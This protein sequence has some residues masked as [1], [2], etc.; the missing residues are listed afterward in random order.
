MSTAA[1]EVPNVRRFV[2]FRIFFNARYYYPVFTILFLDF[3]L[4]LEQFTVLNVIWAL[5]IVFAEVPSGA[6]ADVVGRRNLLLSG[7]ILMLIEMAVLLV[8]PLNGGTLTLAL[9]AINRISSG[10]AEAM[11]SG[12]DEALAYDSLKKEGDPSAWTHVLEHVGKRMSLVMGMVM[13]A[14]ALTYDP[15]FINR[16]TQPLGF[17]TPKEWLIRV[18][19]AL[20]FLHSLVAVWTAWKMREPDPDSHTQGHL[21][22][23]IHQALSQIWKA[24]L[25]LG[26][27]RFILFVILGGLILDSVARQFVILGSEYYR[28]IHIPE[29]AFGFL[30][31]G[32]AAL[33]FL[34][35]KANRYLAER[36]SPLA[37]LFILSALLLIGLTGVSFAFPV[38]GFA[39]VPLIFFM[40]SGVSFLQST[41]INR[42]VDSSLRA[43]MLSFRGLATNLGMALASQSY[44]VL[45]VQ[46]KGRQDPALSAEALQDTV[47][48]KALAYF[49]FYYII[50]LA[51]VLIGGSLFI[52]RKELLF[53][54]PGK[55]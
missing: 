47:F 34:Y 27:N 23:R 22:E 29:F 17:D 28:L 26:G 49:P 45:V 31:A 6:L 1:L 38:V 24:V 19:I 16:L 37:N 21:L 50:L 42:E 4:T 20:T 13:V 15:A 44:A 25:W 32:I 10:L 5:T 40:F 2:R 46:L 8:A 41:Y 55:S 54:I 33:G 14:G 35:A 51:A 18:P 30:S 7:A 3:G 43:T 36:R 52:R 53:S 9:F 11:V 48:I 39:F 12:A